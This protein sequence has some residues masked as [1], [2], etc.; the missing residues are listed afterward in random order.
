MPTYSFTNLAETDSADGV[1]EALRPLHEKDQKIVLREI[2][3]NA[4]FGPKLQAVLLG[5]DGA[6]KVAEWARR[7]FANEVDPKMFPET[8]GTWGA[9]R[10]TVRGLLQSL[11][12]AVTQSIDEMPLSL[13]MKV[14]EGIAQGRRLHLQLDDY[15]VESMEGLGQFEI[16]GSVVS[17]VSGATSSIYSAK[18]VADAQKKIAQIKADTELKQLN[19]NMTLAKAQAAIAQAQGKVLEDTESGKLTGSVTATVPSQD[20]G[21]NKKVGGLPIWSIALAA[22]GGLLMAFK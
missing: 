7:A 18:V 1:M 15:P 17:A 6:H 19:V 4:A 16:I 21:L 8:K 5:P 22:G 11:P 9:F 2:E 20:T 14:V 12:I 10:Q 13:Q 3:E